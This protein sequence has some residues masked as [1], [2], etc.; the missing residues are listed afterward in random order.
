MNI[1][2]NIKYLRTS[3]DLSQLEFGKIAHASDKAVSS[4]ENGTRIPRM[5]V[6]E[7]IAVH[8]GIQKSDIIEGD[9][10]EKLL[11]P[12]TFPVQ[13]K[14]IPLVGTIAAGTPITAEQNINGYFLLDDN[15]KADFALLVKGDSMIGD[16]INDGDIVFIR[17]QPDVENGEMAAV[18][19]DGSATLKRVYKTDK[20][21]EL[22]PANAKYRPLIYS[23]DNCDDIRILGKAI[24]VTKPIV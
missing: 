4:W 2:D 8:F 14:P 12:G 7:R 15:V 23:A 24:A 1:A 13:R 5:G 22:W 21:V 3:H 17:K 16:G 6:I 18:Y 19:I 10:R 11:P 20:S 9:I